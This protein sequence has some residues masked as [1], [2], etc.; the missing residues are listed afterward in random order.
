MVFKGKFANY[1]KDFEFYMKGSFHTQVNARRSEDLDEA[2]I[3]KKL[4]ISTGAAYTQQNMY[5]II[6]SN[7]GNNAAEEVIVPHGLI[8]VCRFA[9]PNICYCCISC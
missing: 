9:K 1:C 2:A 8:R 7:N 3:I 6:T 4:K 5:V